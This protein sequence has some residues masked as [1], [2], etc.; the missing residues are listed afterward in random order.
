MP[1]P[2]LAPLLTGALSGLGSYGASQGLQSLFGGNESPQQRGGGRSGMSEFLGG[3]PG[4][5]DQVGRYNPN[6]ERAF[7]QL[8]SQGLQGLMNPQAGFQPIAN[9][10]RQQFQN[11][12]VPSLAERFTAG[13]GGALSSPAFASQLG[14]A[15]AQLEGNLASGAAQYGMNNQSNLLQ[16]LGMGLQPQ[17]D[18]YQN[19]GQAGFAQNA[20][21]SI[22]S[23]MQILPLLGRLGGEYQKSG[24]KEGEDLGWFWKALLAGTG[25]QA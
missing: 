20:M 1:I 19:P 4:R 6:Q 3:T 11:Q 21:P 17:F 12:T 16:M 10:A 25:G 14:S 18:T 9:Q 24:L 22:S 5:F 7:N 2:F 15:G 13:A 23:I 8:L